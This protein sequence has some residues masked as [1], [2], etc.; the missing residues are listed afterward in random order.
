[1]RLW[2]SLICGLMLA[3]FHCATVRASEVDVLEW[4]LRTSTQVGNGNDA[5]IVTVLANPL[6]G[7]YLAG[8]GNSTADSTIDANWD[9]AGFFDFFL[10][11]EYVDQGSSTDLSGYSR[12][13]GSIWFIPA[14]DSTLTIAAEFNYDLGNGDRRAEL[15]TSVGGGPAPPSILLSRSR[16]AI[17]IGGSP[18]EGTFTIND[19]VP[20]LAGETYVFGYGLELSSHGGSPTSLSMGDGF[21]HATITPVPEPTTAL[22]LLI[23]AASVVAR[24]RRSVPSSTLNHNAASQSSL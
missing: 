4:T 6:L 17:P 16:L 8:I 24:R 22:L 11:G 14:V 9:V 7:N 19:S 21:F 10:T 12:S 2:K 23:V 20:L 13:S 5:R 3:A 18:S 1:M 15:R